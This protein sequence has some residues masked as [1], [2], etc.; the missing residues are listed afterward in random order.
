M[1]GIT[2]ILGITYITSSCSIGCKEAYRWQRDGIDSLDMG[3]I[4]HLTLLFL[5]IK[6]M[7]RD[8]RDKVDNVANVDNVDKV[9]NLY[10]TILPD[11]YVD[12]DGYE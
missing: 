7:L 6:D 10:F 9:D 1:A 5:S 4:F 2:W 12:K 3:Y 8:A 11:S